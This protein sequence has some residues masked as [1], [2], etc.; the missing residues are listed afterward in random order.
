MEK[1]N[2]YSY[3]GLNYIKLI[4][5]GVDC[6]TMTHFPE[7][8]FKNNYDS[9]GLGEKLMKDL[10]ELVSGGLS[11]LESAPPVIQSKVGKYAP[12]MIQDGLQLTKNIA[13][14]QG[15]STA[16]GL[17]SRRYFDS[18][19]YLE[20][21]FQTI[22]S[23]SEF[24]KFW[25]EI[26]PYIM[27]RSGS[28][29]FDDLIGSISQ[30]LSVGSY[31]DNDGNISI[32]PKE[33]GS[34]SLAGA[35]FGN[36]LNQFDGDHIKSYV[37]DSFGTNAGD[38]ENF[39]T[40]QSKR[41]KSVGYDTD[42]ATFDTEGKLVKNDD[43][44]YQKIQY[45]SQERTQKFLYSITSD[46]ESAKPLEELF[47]KLD[48]R[49]SYN[50]NPID[51]R[52]EFLKKEE[53]KSLQSNTASALSV[54]ND[55]AETGTSFLTKP[56]REL[57]SMMGKSVIFAPNKIEIDE[58]QFQIGEN[59]NNRHL[60]DQIVPIPT[61][62]SLDAIDI[63]M[64][65]FITSFNIALGEKV[66]AQLLP[67]TINL[68]I[69]VGSSQK[70]VMGSFSFKGVN[71]DSKNDTMKSVNENIDTFGRGSSESIGK[72]Y[73]ANLKKYQ[74]TFVNADEENSPNLTPKELK[75]ANDKAILLE[76]D[77][78]KEK[79]RLQKT[80]ADC[81][82]TEGADCS[83][84]QTT[85]ENLEKSTLAKMI[86]LQKSIGID[87]HVYNTDP[88]NGRNFINGRVPM[89]CTEQNAVL[90]EMLKRN[91]PMTKLMFNEI[92][93]ELA[94]NGNGGLRGN[95][96]AKVLYGKVLAKQ[97]DNG[98]ADQ[99]SK[100]KIFKKT[101]FKDT[102]E[103]LQEHPSDVT[104][105]LIKNKDG[106]TASGHVATFAQKWDSTKGKFDVYIY[107]SNDG[108]QLKQ[109]TS[110]AMLEAYFKDANI[111]ATSPV[112]VKTGTKKWIK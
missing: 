34:G 1:P 20:F 13:M 49:D 25:R 11:V 41:L 59:E 94:T 70:P 64:K 45:E 33:D 47:K 62:D 72:I 6:G 81:Q 55:L 74:D 39:L 4:I 109:I 91:L 69:S 88:N 105:V 92:Q 28:S 16:G 71:F 73:D 10:I 79:L 51:I 53:N 83:T 100:D 112:L 37:K 24:V 42:G 67:Q 76:N 18:S 23:T 75:D 63:G 36:V 95:E 66:D 15:I 108:R 44:V 104:S 68:T 38:T 86:Q 97:T 21:Q 17:N 102:F 89:Y 77:F 5:A 106:L 8:S 98:V 60:F 7:A 101:S 29:E 32:I 26:S 31:L 46:E 9:G 35:T 61:K 22:L 84:Q 93:R 58:L 87:G 57:G 90:M 65:W 40:S 48:T 14:M 103:F 111:S 43:A 107:N 96:G 30:L 50:D 54:V 52:K 56:F 99:S 2:V 27:A 12:G 78:N 85:L 19:E 82:A 80:L 110:P 3:Q